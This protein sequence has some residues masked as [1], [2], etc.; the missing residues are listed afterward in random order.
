M[1]TPLVFNEVETAYWIDE[2][3]VI[4]RTCDNWNRFAEAN[5][6]GTARSETIIGRSLWDFITG[7]TSR[8][9]LDTLL[10]LARLK[11]APLERSYRCDSPHVQRYMNMIISPAGEVLELRHRVRATIALE[12]ALRLLF[13]PAGIPRCSVCNRLRIDG[14]W[15]EPSSVRRSGEEIIAVRHTVCD[16]CMKNR[17]LPPEGYPKGF[18]A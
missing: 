6:G 5:G 9:W 1:P 15:R 8:M 17:S 3:N 12:P 7:T 4:V 14:E 13:H 2:R 11:K 10:G 16:H 18:A